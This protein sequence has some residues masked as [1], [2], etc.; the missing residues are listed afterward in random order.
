MYMCI[1]QIMYVQTT[2]HQTLVTYIC[3]YGIFFFSRLLYVCKAGRRFCA[4]VGDDKQLI[5]W[6]LSDRLPVARTTL[7]VRQPYLCMYACIYV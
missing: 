6:D 5:L 2:I 7:K 1:V 4:T 3:M